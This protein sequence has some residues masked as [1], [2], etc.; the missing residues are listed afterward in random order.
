MQLWN[1]ERKYSPLQ[2]KLETGKN[3]DL[4]Y[5]GGSVVDWQDLILPGALEL[6]RV[7]ELTP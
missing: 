4:I 6:S 2:R 1:T 7:E 5:E 3:P